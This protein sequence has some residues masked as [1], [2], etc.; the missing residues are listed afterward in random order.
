L[1]LTAGLRH[2]LRA[3]YDCV[4][5][6][7]PPPIPYDQVVRVSEVMDEIFQQLGRPQ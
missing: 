5:S 4:R 3:F 6:G 1:H 7:G 2:G